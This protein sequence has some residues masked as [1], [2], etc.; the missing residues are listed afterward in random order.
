M[1]KHT[2]RSRN[3]IAVTAAETL[4]TRVL[5]TA[6]RGTSTAAFENPDGGVTTGVGTPNFTWGEGFE[7]SLPS[8][9]AFAPNRINARSGKP[10][11]LGRLT[12]FNGETV[13]GTEAN[14]VDLVLEIGLT[15]P[16]IGNAPPLQHTLKMRS[17]ENT[18]D[19]DASADVV[20]LGAGT[21]INIKIKRKNYA[22]R[23]LG[24]GSASSGQF[25]PE[26][27]F[28]VREQAT[29]TA[30]LIAE[31]APVPDLIATRL[32][33]SVRSYVG[34]D[35]QYKVKVKN[36]G[37]GMVKQSFRVD[38][39]L[40]TDANLDAGD[41][42]LKQAGT[43]SQMKPGQT[44]SFKGRFN[45]PVNAPIRYSGEVFLGVIVDPDDTVAESN[46]DNNLEARFDRNIRPITLYDPTPPR[47]IWTDAQNNPL[48]FKNKKAVYA[49]LAGQGYE[50][51]IRDNRASRSLPMGQRFSR[52]TGETM[53]AGAFRIEAYPKKRGGQWMI[54]RQIG[55]P[56]PGAQS[57]WGL[58]AG[59]VLLWHV[60]N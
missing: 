20:S 46:E 47:E 36:A 49:F 42:V 16:E 9:F 56:N 55:E 39:V 50:D 54:E 6:F 19:P 7:G 17:T 30:D 51:L 35:T 1:K 37:N 44:I 8:R 32:S 14:Q 45:I 12:Y 21:T 4:E 52:R 28:V 15:K 60:F 40:S 53:A 25:T 3:R 10:F 38:I 11:S 29:D 5:L 13:I 57:K 31:F 59:Y 22:L 41:L 2:R 34:S 18:D 48:T 43:V 23:I 27:Q 58:L 33:T 26:Q 24:F